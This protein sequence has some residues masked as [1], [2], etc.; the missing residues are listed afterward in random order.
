[1][2]KRD[3]GKALGG[4]GVANVTPFRA[5]LTEISRFFQG[6][7]SVHETMR[8]VVAALDRAGIPYAIAGGM[9]VNAHRH[10]RTTKGVDLL[11]TAAGFAAFKQL[12]A[13]GG[14]TSVAGRPRRFAD[15]RTGVTFD[16]LITGQ[17]PGSGAPGPVAF[18]DPSDVAQVMD[19]LRVVDLPTL[20]QLKLA[21]RRYQDFA[22]V[23]SL[24]RQNHLDESFTNRLHP[25]LH[26]NYMLCLDG[27]RRE[28]EYD[29][30]RDQAP[31]PQ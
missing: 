24:I 1:M 29:A 2:I 4:A 20:V 23:V 6:N 27:K 17:F 12:V 28:D 8:R 16:I 15:A 5:R 11:L 21:A 25:S 14:F 13:A 22:D 18:P 9:A 3:T 26:A 10:A 31:D 30:R 19:D 7:D